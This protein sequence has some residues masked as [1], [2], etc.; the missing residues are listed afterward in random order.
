M[1]VI[2]EKEHLMEA[3]DSNR[4][5]FNMREPSDLKPEDVYAILCANSDRLASTDHDIDISELFDKE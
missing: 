5:T 3:L 1:G 2:I 4:V